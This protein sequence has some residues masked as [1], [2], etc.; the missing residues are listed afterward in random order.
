RTLH[1][2]EIRGA[3]AEE[4]KMPTEVAY[5]RPQLV[6][7]QWRH[8]NGR[9]RFA[10]DPTSHYTKPTDIR[11][12]PLSIVVPFP[13]E[14]RASGINDRGFHPVCWYQREFDVLPGTG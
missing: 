4:E 2:A 9:W 11:T 3:D 5:P 14:S 10:F 8:L 13:P 6:R 7:A 1:H 12:W